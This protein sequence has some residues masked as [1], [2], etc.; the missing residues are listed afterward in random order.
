MLG[1]ISDIQKKMY[2]TNICAK[3][4]SFKKTSFYIS[5]PNAVAKA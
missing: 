3:C 5:P 1:E 4:L 2:F